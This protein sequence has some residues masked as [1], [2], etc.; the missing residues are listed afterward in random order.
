MFF[1][2]FYIKIS[3]DELVQNDVNGKIFNDSNHL[4]EIMKV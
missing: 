1:Q 3:I 4:L 2:F